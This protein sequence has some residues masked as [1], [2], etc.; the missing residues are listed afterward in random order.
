MTPGSTFD[1]QEQTEADAYRDSVIRQ[2]A[3]TPPKSREESMS[4]KKIRATREKK[5]PEPKI[6]RG[7]P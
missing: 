1:P 7:S 6:I 3:N 5:S 4:P 2:M